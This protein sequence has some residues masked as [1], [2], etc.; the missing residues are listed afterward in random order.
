MC[1]NFYSRDMD[2]ITGYLLQIFSMK[3]LKCIITFFAMMFSFLV[4]DVNIA[5]VACGILYI[6]DFFCGI[7]I[8]AYFGTFDWHKLYR[9][10][11]K[12]ILYGIWIIVWH[13]VDLL[14][15][16]STLEFWAQN[17][18]IVYLWVT[19]ALSIMRH[20]AWIGLHI[21]KKLINRL[22]RMQ[23]EFNS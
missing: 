7:L 3:A 22:E 5:L 16:H 14:V 1:N 13:M 11:F 6:I 17:V 10:V 15:A 19:E 23:N 4:G 2:I 9:W 12:F 8:N 21:P 20:L 18:F